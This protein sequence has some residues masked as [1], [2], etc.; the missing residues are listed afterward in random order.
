MPC[1]ALAN[2]PL[3][4]MYLSTCGR[5]GGK[6]LP[7]SETALSAEATPVGGQPTNVDLG[8]LQ[9]PQGGR[10]GNGQKNC[11]E[12]KL[13][14]P[15]KYPPDEK[16]KK[17]KK[18]RNEESNHIYKKSI[19]SRMRH[20]SNPAPWLPHPLQRES[21]GAMRLPGPVLASLLLLV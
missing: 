18:R 12:P 16:R 14:A 7:Q 19:S 15:S 3:S 4:T 2:M 17:K 1:L 21:L 5:S 9:W 6:S 8:T 10:Q 13:H 20:S 11:P